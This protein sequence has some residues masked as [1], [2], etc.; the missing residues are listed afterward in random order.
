MKIILCDTNAELVDAWNEIFAHFRTEVG[1]GTHEVEI[2]HGSIFDQKA[3]ALVSPANS[4]GF[5]D[6]G[7][8]YLI[9]EMIGW[10]VQRKLQQYIKENTHGELLVGQAAVIS[11]TSDKFKFV[12]SAPTMRAPMILGAN[13][14]NVYLATKAVLFAMTN[15]KLSSVAI[16][17]MGTGVGKVPVEVCAKQ[18]WQACYDVLHC[19]TF[20]TSWREAQT[21]HQLLTTDP[22]NV[23]DLQKL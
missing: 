6:G 18:M 8:D 1:D 17:G 10:D 9:S 13:S 3:D 23:R 2:V 7:L 20:P 16:P 5:M 11:T 14:V 12:I 4:F 22:S 15:C 19:V 21:R